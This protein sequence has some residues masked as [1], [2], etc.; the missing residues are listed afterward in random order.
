MEFSTLSDA[1]RAVVEQLAGCARRSAVDVLASLEDR[2]SSVD[3]EGDF[4][5]LD[6]SGLRDL[7]GDCHLKHLPRLVSVRFGESSLQVLTIQDCP[8]LAVLWCEHQQLRSSTR[9]VC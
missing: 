7:S 8:S 3:Q 2:G 5:H 9:Q 6:M 4:V 1:S